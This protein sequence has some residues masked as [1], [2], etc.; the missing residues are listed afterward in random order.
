MTIPNN[1]R[2]HTPGSPDGT[3]PRGC[4][5]P[6]NGRGAMKRIRT[7]L[8]TAAVTAGLACLFTLPG[9]AQA[10]LFD[11]EDAH[12][13]VFGVKGALRENVL[14]YIAPLEQMLRS[15]D[16]DRPRLVKSVK[17]AMSALGYFEPEVTVE[18]LNVKN[19]KKGEPRPLLVR[20][21]PGEPVRIAG[22]EV[23]IRGEGRDFE[24]FRKVLSR[25]PKK[26]DV[27]DQGLYESVKSDLNTEAMLYGY[28]NARFPVHELAVSPARR[29]AFWRLVFETGP[30]WTFG[31]LTIEGSELE[32]RMIESLSPF[33]VGEPYDAAKV[34]LYNRRLQESDWFRSAIVAP[35]GPALSPDHVLPMDANLVMQ[36]K[37]RM[38]VGL[39]VST[40]VGVHGKLSWNKPWVN[41]HGHS[42]TSTTALSKPEQSQDFTYKVP[43]KR[44]PLTDYWLYQAGGRH[45]KLNDTDQSSWVLGLSR[46]HQTRT[47]WKL[48]GTLRYSV[49]Q[50]TQADADRQR[51]KIFM[52]GI[53]ATRTR[54][55][56][57]LSPS[58]GDT[59]RYSVDIAQKGFLS[60]VTFARVTAEN[61]WLRTY[62]ENHRIVVRARAGAIATPDFDRIPPDLRFFAGGDNSVR[63]Y[64]YQKLSPR[65]ADGE[66]TG[67]R[68]LV[69]G[70]I[71]YRHRI[72]GNWWG[73]VFFDAG[74]AVN[75]FKKF[76]PKE[77]A[78]FGVRWTSPVGP[79][80]FDLAHPVGRKDSHEKRKWHF[81]IGL[82]SVL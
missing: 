2:V 66:L 5:R 70:S 18:T 29:E 76:R 75:S 27:L 68:Y 72:T 24:P 61:I 36:D 6:G 58:W 63:G 43:I 32:P 9:T 54:Q 12:I 62:R 34:S 71:E 59:Q 4:L 13:A 64:G 40:D 23:E 3:D 10:G 41:R 69:T 20:I 26:G 7:L 45:S 15:R 35:S 67:G 51:T 78:G 82:G 44:S 25:L 74:D 17:T 77:G 28:F 14:A 22:V 38:E 8:T 65:N 57:G 79:I 31:N 50:F 80:K 19:L 52:P 60:D 21:H 73:A 30:R 1:T 49:N 48:A 33:R 47:G 81:Y 37:N 56:G 42:F 11:G 39:G 16:V 53:S 46:M 55:R